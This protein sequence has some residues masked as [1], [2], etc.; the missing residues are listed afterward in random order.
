MLY[1]V[2]SDSLGYYEAV[3]IDQVQG[4]LMK[5]TKLRDINTVSPTSGRMSSIGIC[6]IEFLGPVQ[7]NGESDKDCSRYAPSIWQFLIER[8][9]LT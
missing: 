5:Q 1:V 6:D 7:E 8:M 4:V 9:I 3:R 2:T